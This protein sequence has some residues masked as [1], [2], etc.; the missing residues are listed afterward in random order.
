MNLLM[1][2]TSISK[3]TL[4]SIY[5]YSKCLWSADLNG[6]ERKASGSNAHADVP[7]IDG[8]KT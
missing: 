3:L 5:V 8:T 2:D 6:R 7:S 1:V 4:D